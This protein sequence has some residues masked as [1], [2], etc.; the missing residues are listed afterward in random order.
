LL[1]KW[2]ETRSQTALQQG[3]SAK[4]EEAA[5]ECGAMDKERRLPW[6]RRC[7]CTARSLELARGREGEEAPWEEHDYL[8]AIAAVKKKRQE[9]RGWQL[10]RNGGVGV[11]N[12]QFARERAPIYR[13]NPRVRVSIGPNGPEWTWPKTLNRVA[14]NYFQSKNAPVEFVATEKQSEIEF[15]RTNN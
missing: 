4:E 5:A 6:G 1:E 12:C 11:K 10:R 13:R 7:C 3:T 9:G 2:E 14:L 8:M 15:G